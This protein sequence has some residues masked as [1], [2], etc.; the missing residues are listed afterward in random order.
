[1]TAPKLCV[2]PACPHK[3]DPL[4]LH[5]PPRR[6]TPALAAALAALGRHTEGEAA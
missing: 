6:R 5:V 1:M 4:W 3:H 2:V